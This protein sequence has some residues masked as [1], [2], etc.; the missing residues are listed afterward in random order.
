VTVLMRN[1]LEILV[2]LD[3]KWEKLRLNVL[4]G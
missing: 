3:P 2:A 4:Q 1:V